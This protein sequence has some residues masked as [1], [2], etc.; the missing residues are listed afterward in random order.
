[1]TIRFR[2]F[3]LLMAVACG[4]LFTVAPMVTAAPAVAC[5]TGHLSDPYTGQC[6][7]VGGVPT[8]NGIPCMGRH[9]GT[10]LGFLQNLPLPRSPQSGL[11]P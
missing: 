10:C 11:G 3:R 5:P 6:Y 1:M 7:V 9:L 2:L 4:V 8:V